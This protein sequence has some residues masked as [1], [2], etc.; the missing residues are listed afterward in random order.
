MASVL[1]LRLLYQGLPYL[2]ASSRSLELS[3]EDVKDAQMKVLS[4]WLGIHC[5][6]SIKENSTDL[7]QS[8]H[9]GMIILSLDVNLFIPF[10]SYQCCDCC[11]L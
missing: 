6:T 5:R 11:V 7:A 3:R 9:K 4:I 8:C 10:R 2:K 1:L